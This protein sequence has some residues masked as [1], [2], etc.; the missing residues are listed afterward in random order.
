MA[1]KRIKS[2]KE[3]YEFYLSE[4]RHRTTRILHFIGT[5]LG[6]HHDI[7]GYRGRLGLGLVPRAAGGLW[8]CLG[9]PCFL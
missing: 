4:H 6:L 1:E 3:F 8:F 5:F 2:Y 9:W 7:P